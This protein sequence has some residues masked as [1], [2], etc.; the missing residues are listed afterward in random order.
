MCCL[1]VTVSHFL[2]YT[3]YMRSLHFENTKKSHCARFK[4]VNNLNW[5]NKK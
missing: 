1:C 5:E 4:F 2:V 3:I